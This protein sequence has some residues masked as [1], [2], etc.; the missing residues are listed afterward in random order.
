MGKTF[1][2]PTTFADYIR[3]K[4]THPGKHKK[5][6]NGL[7]AILDAQ[8]DI[9]RTT[10]RSFK[11][12]GS[13]STSLQIRSDG[14]TINV[15]GN[16]GRFRRPDNVFNYTADDTK[17]I[18]NN[19]LQE[20]SLPAFTGGKMYLTE[21][22]NKQHELE[23]KTCTTG[24]T[25][26]EIHYTKNF[27]AGSAQ[28]AKDYLYA[29]GRVNINRQNV[30]AYPT[31]ATFGEGSRFKSS[32]IYNKAED[33]KRLIKKG[34]LQPTE[35]IMALI[36]YCE[37]NG[38]VRCETQFR[39]ILI[40]NNLNFWSELT[41]QSIDKCFQQELLLMTKQSEK[42]D[43]ESLPQRLRSTYLLYANGF[44][45]KNVLANGTYYRHRNELLKYGIDIKENTNI[46]PLVIKQKV[47]TLTDAVMPDFYEL[48]D[49]KEN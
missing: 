28:N 16:F 31:G 39:N 45:V 8:G 21:Y 32:K 19:V 22:P 42:L 24:A 36:D 34:K 4:Q 5:L 30:K 33:L 37:T 43:L 3:V 7:V 14:K 9:E 29:S 49:I 10:L 11:L 40:R 13:H 25:I 47:I 44:N 2:T 18:I 41:H 23:I 12:E 46:T 35:Y 20:L 6:N 38:I 48:P 15:S 27:A 1:N 17:K 26:S